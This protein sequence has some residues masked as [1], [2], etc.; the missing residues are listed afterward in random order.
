MAA[1]AD[2]VDAQVAAV[3]FEHGE[4]LLMAPTVAVAQLLKHQ[5]SSPPGM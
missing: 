4:G 2:A 3:D 1:L 5:L